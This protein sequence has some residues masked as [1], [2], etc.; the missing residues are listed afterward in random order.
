MKLPPA[1]GIMDIIRAADEAR[2]VEFSR[3]RADLDFLLE[4][5]A[6][7]DIATLTLADISAALDRLENLQ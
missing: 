6:L 2:G 5:E 3:I 7:S 4:T 1:P